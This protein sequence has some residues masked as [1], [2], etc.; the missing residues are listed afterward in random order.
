MFDSVG[1]GVLFGRKVM[2]VGR[3]LFM[4]FYE[5]CGEN[6]VKSSISQICLSLQKLRSLALLWSKSLALGAL[7]LA[8]RDF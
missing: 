8:K 1:M 6:L 5:N 2:V 4:G 3:R 7:Y